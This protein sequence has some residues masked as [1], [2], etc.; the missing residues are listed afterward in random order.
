VPSSRTGVPEQ[1]HARNTLAGN[2]LTAVRADKWSDHA[3]WA[4]SELA[5]V[6]IK[7]NLHRT[8]PSAAITR[9]Y[10]PESNS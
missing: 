1:N 6:R 8:Y 9:G 3:P 10:L 4:C 2:V 5:H 7:H